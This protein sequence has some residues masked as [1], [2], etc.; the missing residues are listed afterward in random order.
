MSANPRCCLLF[1]SVLKTSNKSDRIRP[2]LIS[3]SKHSSF[4]LKASSR[5]VAAVTLI[6]LQRFFIN[7]G[8]KCNVRDNALVCNCTLDNNASFES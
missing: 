8:L 4:P 6:Q 2:L 5:A 3:I 7:F 1:Q